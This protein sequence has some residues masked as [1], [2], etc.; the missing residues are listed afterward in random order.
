MA[1]ALSRLQIRVG[2]PEG[3]GLCRLSSKYSSIRFPPRF[4]L[5]ALWPSANPKKAAIIKAIKQT[6]TTGLEPATT[7]STIRCSNQLSYVPWKFQSPVCY[8]QAHQTVKE[9]RPIKMDSLFPPRLQRVFRA[10]R[11]KTEDSH[12]KSLDAP[13]IVTVLH[14]AKKCR[15]G[16]PRRRTV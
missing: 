3:R 15:R 7:G 12:G 2:W 8:G 4:V 10:L 16:L 1:S 6:G 13:A 9:R 14:D 11:K 5:T